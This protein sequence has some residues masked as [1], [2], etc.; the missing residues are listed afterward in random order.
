MIASK[1][2]RQN[3]INQ[4]G[5]GPDA[6]GSLLSI[7]IPA[8]NEA[9]YIG[10]TLSAVLGQDRTAGALEIVVSANAC[11]DGTE[12]VVESFMPQFEARGWRLIVV[13]D[14]AP[15]K[16]GALNRADAAA[17]GTARIYLDADVICSP[18]LIGELRE[19]LASEKP[20]Y[21]TGTLAVRPAQ[22]WVT[23]RYADFWIRLPFIQGGA[24]GAG[25]FAVNEAGRTRWGAFPDII[26][27]DTFVRLNFAPD[28]RIE[29][30]ALYHWPMVEGFA[31][32][33][34]VRRRQNN[35]VDE[36]Y[37]HWP[38]LR[39]NEGK[40]SLGIG[41][42]VSLALRVPVSFTVYALVALAVKAQPGGME[43]SR[44]R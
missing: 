25:L 8:N 33:V 3:G 26:S 34:K 19:V 2:M 13:S 27:D 15:G 17:S 36:V 31:R 11:I 7:I 28:E 10:E 24:V 6:A 38:H 43:W 20:V 12:T 30:P 9:A 32:L 40:A 41:G 37:Q 5:R 39:E 22:S 29:V 42:L 21:A 18:A 44:G 16:V 14:A 1:G 35:G 4:P 23:R